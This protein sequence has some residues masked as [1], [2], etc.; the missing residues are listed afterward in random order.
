MKIPWKVRYWWVRNR[1][2]IQ[3]PLVRR[4]TLVKELART[5]GALGQMLDEQEKATARLAAEITRL[6]LE[7]GPAQYGTRWTM[8]VS[9]DETFMR[10]ATSLKELSSVVIPVLARRIEAEVAHID[11]SR[12]KPVPDSDR[13]NPRFTFDAMRGIE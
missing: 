2:R 8:T 6:R 12:A 9:F 10:H 7:V 11:F 3:W 13:K 4:S 1:D 5:R